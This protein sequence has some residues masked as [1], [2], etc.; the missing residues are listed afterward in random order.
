MQRR[1]FLRV[2]LTSAGALCIGVNLP[3]CTSP[4]VRRM[5]Q[6]AERGE[7]KPSIY[8]TITPDDRV[9]VSTGKSEMG[10]GTYST[11]AWLIAEE[12]EVD[13]ATIEIVP[14][15]GPAFQ[16]VG[17]QVTGGSTS[18][19]EAWT[20]LRT[21][22]ATARL[23]LTTAA[24]RIWKTPIAECTAENGAIVHAKTHRR[25][26]YG[27]LIPTAANLSI[28]EDVPLKPTTAHRVIGRRLP[29]IDLRPKVTG[30]PIFGLDVEVEGMVRALVL[31]PPVLG[32]TL[33]TY[34]ADAAR[35]EPGIIDIFP[36]DAGLAIVA[37]KYWQARRAAARVTTVW[38]HGQNA[39]LDT[40]TLTAATYEQ[41]KREGMTHRSEGNPEDA[42]TAK[43]A[44]TLEA[45]YAG[46][47]LAHAPLEPQNATAHVERDRVRIWAP[48]Q[49]QS[50]AQDL[51]A[52]ITGL[53]RDQ[54]EL[55]TTYLGGGFGRRGVTDAIAEALHISKRIARP[56]Q[57]IWTRE[58]D[59]RGGF[60]R[61]LMLARMTAAL[62]ADGTPQAFTGHAISKSVFALTTFAQSTLPEG[63]P[64]DVMVARALGQL[65]TT[66]TVADS[67]ATEGIANI[68]YRFPH[69]RVDYTPMRVDI[70]VTFW[71]SVG[72]SVNAF[73]VEGFIDEIAHAAGI[74]PLEFRRSLLPEDSRER[75]VLDAA[76]ALGQWGTP[77]EPGYGRGIAVHASFGSYCA[78]VIE[79][80]VIDGAIHVRRV[81][82]AIDCG[83]Q[84]NPDQIEA[85]M[86]S[87]IIF[88]L[89]AALWQRIDIDRGKV[90]QGNFDTYPLMRID[91]TPEITITLIESTEPP[92]GV[93]EPGM[94]PAAP[95]LAN[96]LFAATGRRLR[97]L[98]LTD[99][100][101]EVG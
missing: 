57:V 18:T 21:A 76:A 33:T 60:Y 49:F 53:S 37:H 35:T 85:Q 100:L 66:G 6:A 31:H 80:G 87:C 23:M 47:F 32:G 72:H 62:S 16:N 95:A 74:D 5:R 55:H 73:A 77:V 1:T 34:N 83:I 46:P 98:P 2:A 63:L 28:P 59:T 14:Q 43:G 36:I 94:P 45:T 44:R 71:R 39:R 15:A 8:I 4:E 67:I 82:C 48:T 24:A 7:F 29:R 54:V 52:R 65:P 40:T 81:T 22:G 42:F 61:P 38:D 93:G 70:P 19:Q 25:L 10:Q 90:R 86:E 17:I 91:Q 69:I 68:P 58:E 20:P 3:S 78:Q 26:R 92:T 64:Q 9:Q 56:V 99:A 96:A 75:K 50:G 11:Y 101:N 84:I 88:G 89:S 97:T 79:A 12:L 51:A 30:A 13:P 41:S 27:E